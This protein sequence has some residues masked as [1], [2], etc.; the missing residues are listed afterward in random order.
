M[1]LYYVLNVCAYMLTVRMIQDIPGTVIKHRVV[2]VVYVLMLHLSDV[3]ERGKGIVSQCNWAYDR[4][5]T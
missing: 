1:L 2:N 3:L 4:V 5:E